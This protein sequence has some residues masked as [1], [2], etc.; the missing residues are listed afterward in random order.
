MSYGETCLT[1]CVEQVLEA[2]G[3]RSRK[4]VRDANTALEAGVERLWQRAGGRRVPPAGT[5]IAAAIERALVRRS[6][7]A[8]AEQ[9]AEKGSTLSGIS[10]AANDYAA[11]HHRFPSSLKELQDNPTRPRLRWLAEIAGNGTA[12]GYVFEYQLT[13]TSSD[14]VADGF[15]VN[16]DPIEQN[17]TGTLHFYVDKTR[18]IRVNWVSRADKNSPDSGMK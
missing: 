12:H 4:I 5:E 1:P 3:S 9:A 16:A 18:V 11:E 6:P 10:A 17:R 2:G 8:T 14:G 15:Q 7:L 13:S